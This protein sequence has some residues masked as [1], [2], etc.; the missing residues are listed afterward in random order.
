MINYMN[1]CDC[2][3]EFISNNNT[4][5]FSTVLL[6]LKSP[7]FNEY[8]SSTY[9]LQLVF[10]NNIFTSIMVTEPK[11]KFLFDLKYPQ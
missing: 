9:G 7:D 2:W 6:G 8:I 4:V 3:L 10:N 1:I 5:D 11:K